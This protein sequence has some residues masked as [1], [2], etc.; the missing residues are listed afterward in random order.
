MT[1]S[2]LVTIEELATL[3]NVHRET[4][5]RLL[6]QQRVPGGIRLGKRWYIRRENLEAWLSQLQRTPMADEMPLTIPS[7]P[8]PEDTSP[9]AAGLAWFRERML[10]AAIVECSDDTIFSKTLDG[11][12]LSWNTGAERMYGYSAHEIVGRPVNTLVPPDYPDDVPMLM[13]RIRRGERIDHYETRRCRKDGR[14]IDVS[15]SISPVRDHTGKIVAAATIAR[16]ITERKHA[17]QR[18]RE[19]GQERERL[20]ERERQARAKAEKNA[21][22]LARLQTVTAALV[23]GLTSSQIGELVVKHGAEVLGAAT[24]AF[25]RALDG[26]ASFEIDYLLN[27]RMSAAQQQHWRR[28]PAN[29]R[30]PIAY[31][32]QTGQPLWFDSADEMV[33]QFP[34][35]AE[36]ASGYPGSS[37]ML[38]LLV[39]GRPLG[40]IS[41]TFDGSRRFTEDEQR[42]M[43]AL[44]HQGAQA[45]ERARLIE[46]AKEK[47]ALEERQRLARDLHDAVSQTLFAATT[48]A[49]SIPRLWKNNPERGLEQLD[50]VVQLNR[51]AMSEMRILLLELRPENIVKTKLSDLCRHLTE[52]L[53]GR[54]RIAVDCTVEG[55][56]AAIPPEAHLAL[57]RIAQ[58]SVNNIIKHSQATA[59]NIRLSYQAGRLILTIE[60][61]GRGFDPDQPSGGLG[62]R[63]MRERA[64]ALG[65][66]YQLTS[67][68]GKGTQIRV[69]WAKPDAE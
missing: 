64:E 34:D 52:A 3:L 36:F 43:L 37:A 49:E 8:D 62:L 2:E 39:N 15:L 10:L 12:I 30:Y 18:A 11:I 41:F 7:L 4:A 51:V 50:Q 9:V 47:A 46:E 53:K 25:L 59:V 63:S 33:R 23:E 22:W 31:A 13:A 66:T 54:K 60:D 27:S 5:R 28:F 19:Q 58:E 16:D 67:R 6:R 55:E 20:L 26:G 56:E 61:N 48:V 65:A 17:E 24:G 69:E 42:L 1:L 45:L 35:M 14:V 38:P 44:A 32:V 40:A 68:P 29:P 57:Y 21:R